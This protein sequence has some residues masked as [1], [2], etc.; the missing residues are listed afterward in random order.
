MRA[1]QRRTWA[2]VETSAKQARGARDS[3]KAGV[4]ARPE[5]GNKQWPKFEFSSTKHA[6]SCF[7]FAHS[8]REALATL[9]VLAAPTGAISPLL[10]S[11]PSSSGPDLGGGRPQDC[12]DAVA[13]AVLQGQIRAQYACSRGNIN[14]GAMSCP[15]QACAGGEDGGG[16]DLR[17][18]SRHADRGAECI[19][20]TW[21]R[22]GGHGTTQSQ[23]PRV[24][25]TDR[26][27]WESSNVP[28][29]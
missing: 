18:Q 23:D 5:S 28:L 10:T 6:H 19:S 9:A 17:A 26:I 14:P 27:V 7:T 3:A 29:S 1:R 16:Q 12:D 8:A 13:A 25:I 11:A 2:G 21:P 22:L 24:A 4:G 15:W 20:A